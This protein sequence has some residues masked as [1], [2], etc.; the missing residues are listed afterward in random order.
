[1]KEVVAVINVIYR[2][3]TDNGCFLDRLLK[4]TPSIKGPQLRTKLP[5][6]KPL[7]LVGC[8]S[9]WAKKNNKWQFGTCRDSSHLCCQNLLKTCLQ[10]LLVIKKAASTLRMDMD[11]QEC[12]WSAKN[13]IDHP[14][15]TCY[16]YLHVPQASPGR[17]SHLV[18][19]DWPHS[20][21]C[22]SFSSST[23][24]HSSISI[25]ASM[26]PLPMHFVY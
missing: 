8:F 17:D 7:K 13:G 3:S 9:P 22:G 24:S 12:S 19:R 4:I 20:C 2:S 10:P 14:H 1:M 23:C 5:D 15:S 21:K 25:F 6:E 18:R 26:C 16:L 11:P